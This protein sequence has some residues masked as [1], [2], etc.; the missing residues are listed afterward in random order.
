MTT[1]TQLKR[2]ID[3]NPPRAY[4]LNKPAD[5]KRLFHEAWGYLHTCHHKHGTDWA[6]R[7]LA[8]DALKRLSEVE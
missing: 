2:L 8:M 4:D 7:Q 3:E 1:E 6:G 5:L